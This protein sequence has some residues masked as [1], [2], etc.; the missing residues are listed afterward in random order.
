V[1][2]ARS[3]SLTERDLF[4][5]L[6]VLFF[7][8]GKTTFFREESSI[9]FAKVIADETIFTSEVFFNWFVEQNPHVPFDNALAQTP[10]SLQDLVVAFPFSISVK[11][12]SLRWNRSS[13]KLMPFFS[14]YAS[15]WRIDLIITSSD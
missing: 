13:R 9:S 7:I 8:L 6:V 1:I 4:T 15:N 5:R 3:G 12:L 2:V 11:I 10:C 14:P